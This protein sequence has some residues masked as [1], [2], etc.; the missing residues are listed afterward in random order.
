M[1]INYQE[2]PFYTIFNSLNNENKSWHYERLL[3]TFDKDQV[4]LLQKF[5]IGTFHL[6][7]TN[8]LMPEFLINEEAKASL[9]YPQGFLIMEANES[10]YTNRSELESY[11][12][13]FT[14]DGEGA[15]QYR[16]QKYTIKKG[17]GF[18]INCCEPHLYYTTGT[19]WTSTI[20]H[21][22]GSMVG[23]I[24]NKYAADGNVKFSASSCPNFEMLQFQVLKASQKIIPYRDYKISCLID[25]LLTELLTSKSEN[26]RMNTKGEV[27]PQ[28]INYLGT[29]YTEDI[30]IEQLT[31]NFGINRTKLCEEFKNYTGF[32]IKQYLLTLRINYAKLLLQSTQ[33]SI[34]IISE[35]AGFHDTAHFIHLFKKNI[36]V[37]PLQFRKLQ[38]RP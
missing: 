5:H 19:Q 1:S 28:I 30:T 34:D 9:N 38:L 4:S 12:L 3:H 10:Y 31:H 14:L 21:I 37:T 33:D 27:L 2:L 26:F 36:G 25:I 13:R 24:F 17:D 22:N 18:F 7:G 32:T 23:T 11:E 29:H 8:H 20:F 6:S 35:K 16:G 15:L